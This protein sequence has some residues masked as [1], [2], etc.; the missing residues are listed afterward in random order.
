MRNRLLLLGLALGLGA[1]AEP[2]G[3]VRPGSQPE[4]VRADQ[5]DCRAQAR[6]IARRDMWW[7]E[8]AFEGQRNTGTQERFSPVLQRQM[9]E[10]DYRD[11]EGEY[12]VDCMQARGY[13][14]EM[15]RRGF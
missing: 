1:C 10:A 6:Q 11:R 7:R 4:Q 9:F 14:R 12:L 15:V 13:T 2:S 3:W 5:R 8:Q